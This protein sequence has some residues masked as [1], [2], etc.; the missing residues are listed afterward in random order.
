M[1]IQVLT[2]HLS[3]DITFTP[4]CSCLAIN[5]CPYHKL[6]TT[7]SADVNPH[8]RPTALIGIINQ[9]THRCM[10]SEIDLENVL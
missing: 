10:S 6:L 5:S 4:I 3:R 9:N 1:V 7:C 8:N 2:A